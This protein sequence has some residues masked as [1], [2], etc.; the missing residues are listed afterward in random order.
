[1][2]EPKFLLK[3][4]KIKTFNTNMMNSE[5]NKLIKTEKKNPNL[6]HETS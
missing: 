3:N 4:I 6:I 1:M 2:Q 5:N